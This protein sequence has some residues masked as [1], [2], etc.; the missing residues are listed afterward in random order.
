M[1]EVPYTGHLL[2]SEGIKPDSNK[3]EAV[4]KCHNQRMCPRHMKRFLGMVNYP[5]KFL[6]NILTIS[7][8]LPQLEAKDVE[9]HWDDNEQKAFDEVKT[10]IT[11]HPVLQY[12]VVTK[13]LT[14]QCDASQSGVGAAL[15]REGNPVAFTSRAL[16]ST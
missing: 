12:Y 1:T 9:W 11:C 4:Q 2:T 5:S 7:E 15:L 14:L 3:V 16:N 10:L 13:E 8:P 6:P